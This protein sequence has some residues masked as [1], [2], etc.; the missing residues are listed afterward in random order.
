MTQVRQ[1]TQDPKLFLHASMD[2]EACTYSYD[3]IDQML[4]CHAPVFTEADSPH[5]M[6][7][8]PR[9]TR[10]EERMPAIVTAFIEPDTST[11]SIDRLSKLLHH[12]PS[13][14]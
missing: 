5:G 3:S 13:A 7:D 12:I 9:D 6:V 4:T 10:H 8:A 11:L 14:A 2:D 1:Q